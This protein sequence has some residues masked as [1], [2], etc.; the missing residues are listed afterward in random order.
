MFAAHRDVGALVF[1]HQL[2]FAVAFHQGGALHHHP[3]FGPVV[4]HLQ[5]EAGARFHRDSLH[6]PAAVFHH[7][8]VMGPG[9]IDLAVRLAFWA[10]C[11]LQLLHHG[12]DLLSF[13]TISDQ[14]GVVGFHHHQV[15]DPKTHNQA[16]FAAYVA[17]AAAFGD[18]VALQHIPLGIPLC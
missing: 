4:M 14:N 18:H 8:G 6:L 9:A 7:T 13:G 12:F 10:T 16:V 2:L 3:V 15:L 17:V 11:I 5:G 1:P